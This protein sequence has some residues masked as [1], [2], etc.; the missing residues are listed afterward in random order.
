MKAMLL[1]AGRG[2]RMGRLT[3]KRPKPLLSLGPETLID[4]HLRRLAAAGVDDIVINLSYRGEQIRAAIGET[5][6]WGPDRAI[7]R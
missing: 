4:R 5:T 6:R 7:Q 1:A 2:E 3:A